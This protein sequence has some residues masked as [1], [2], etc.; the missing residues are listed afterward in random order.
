MSNNHFYE[1]E[2]KDVIRETDD[3]VSVSFDVPNDMIESFSY[4][5]GQ[6]LTLEADINGEKVRRSYSLCSAPHESE[7]KV[8]IKKIPQGKFST[9]ANDLLR[10][11]DKLS[12]MNPMG[13]F[14]LN[15]DSKN[16]NHYVSF[17]AGSGITPMMSM[18]KEV[19]TQEPRL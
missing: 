14:K 4:V 15:I 12:V 3:C 6:Y 11:G 1:L 8:A 19:L 5:P 9:F 10:K 2:V 13:N 18:I 17:A 7:W 16:E